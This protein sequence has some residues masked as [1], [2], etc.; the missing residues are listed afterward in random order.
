M[1]SPNPRLVGWALLALLL[2][3]AKAV[4]H[5]RAER[6]E[7]AGA[8]LPPA[9][10]LQVQVRLSQATLQPGETVRGIATVTNRGTTT[11]VLS[12]VGAVLREP[13]ADRSATWTSADGADAVSVQPGEYAELPFVLHIARCPGAAPLTP[14]FYELL[15][16]LSSEHGLEGSPARAVVVSPA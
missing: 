16:L 11:R 1:R 9:T 6:P 7:C 12:A 15:V 8:L 13:A 14:G 10:R 4:A 5:L 3:D 2:A